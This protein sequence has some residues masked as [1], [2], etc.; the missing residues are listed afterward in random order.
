ML[1]GQPCRSDGVDGAAP[2]ESFR[3]DEIRAGSVIDGQ[4][5]G[6]D[7]LPHEGAAEYATPLVVDVDDVAV[8]DA[9][10]SCGARVHPARLVQVAVPAP[11][12]AGDRFLGPGDVV[13]LG[14]D[15]PPAV[16]G[17][18]QQ[19]VDP[20]PRA[21][22]ALVVGDALLD[23]LREGRPLFVGGEGGCHALG[24]EL[25][26][27]GRR[28]QR[29]GHRVVVEVE[30]ARRCVSA[31]PSRRERRSSPSPGTPPSSRTCSKP[32]PSK[33]PL[34]NSASLKPSVTWSS[35]SSFSATAQTAS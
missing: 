16:V 31:S 8:F 28:G 19:R 14:V 23:P 15:P 30:P 13:A 33:T 32:I 35:M 29:I 12:L 20:R 25:E 11:D 26:L 22:D 27:A 9:S 21:R 5:A 3:N 4:N 17:H 1:G 6:H 7:A 24:V 34:I 2:V 18:H 10:L